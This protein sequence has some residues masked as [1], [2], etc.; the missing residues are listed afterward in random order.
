MSKK[1]S[2]EPPKS[3]GLE[4]LKK[5]FLIGLGATTVTME[6][7]Q[8]LVN[9]MV[10]RGELGQGEAKKFAEDLKK[11][12]VQEKASFEARLQELVEGHLKAALR[13][14]GLATQADLESLRQ[15]MGGKVEKPRKPMARKAKPVAKKTAS[16][17]VAKKAASK[18]AAKATAKPV[19]KKAKPAAKKPVA[20]KKAPAK[21][22]SGK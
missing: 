4:S 15:E 19:A 20:G 8:E 12:A 16:R 13:K 10:S 14:M 17:T 3:G 18:P 11:R 6:R 2:P 21:R 1:Q 5:A 7:A 9:D 22:A